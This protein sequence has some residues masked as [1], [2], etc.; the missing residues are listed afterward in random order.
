MNLQAPLHIHAKL[1]AFSSRSFVS[2]VA[3]LAREAA[4]MAPDLE[5][6]ANEPTQCYRNLLQCK[7]YEH[8]DE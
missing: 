1:Q 8:K 3:F 4:Y 2:R 5:V 6:S 7:V